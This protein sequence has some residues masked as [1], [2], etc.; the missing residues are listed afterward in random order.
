MYFGN[1]IDYNFLKKNRTQDPT[2]LDG[3]F[4]FGMSVREQSENLNRTPYNHRSG[5]QYY[6]SLKE[7]EKAYF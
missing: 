5:D 1:E 2:V 4:D 6:Q 7:A 3:F